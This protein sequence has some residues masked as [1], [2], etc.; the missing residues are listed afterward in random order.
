M[1]KTIIEFKNVSKTYADT[2]T[3]V[4]KDISF[5]LEEG[6]FYT[7]LGA[8]GSGKSTILNIIAG[9][10]DATDGDVILDDKRINDLPAN[11]RNVHTIFQ[12]YALFPNMNVF[13]NVA[14]A[15]KIKGVDKK[16]IAKR[17]SESLKLVRLDGFEKRSITKLSGGQK[18]RVAIARAI[19]DRPKV[20]LLDES[21][22]ALD[23]KLRKDMQY[24]L[25]ELQKSLG[26]TFIFVTHDQE[27]ALA[28]SDWVFI[29]NEGEI[30]Q[31]G[32]PTDIY[33]EPINHFVADFIGESNI[34]N[35]K[36]IE[37]Y[38]VEFNG[39]KFEAVD[40]GMRKNEPIEVVIRP[41]DIWFTLPNEGKFNVKVDTQ[42]FRGVH[43]EIVA[44]DEFNNEWLIHSTHKAIV[45]ETVG[46]DFDPEAIHIMRLN[47]SEEEFDARIE[48]YVE[49]EETVGL[50]KAVEE[51][52]AEEEAAI[53]EAVKEALENTME[54]TELAETVNEI[55]QKQE[56]ETENSESGD[57]K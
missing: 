28:M 40:G 34:L 21:L 20:L 29:M 47:E 51:E 48:E 26:I 49:E 46:L 23:M 12:S 14:F 37:D 53:Q 4:L 1:S 38:L 13:D 55:L 33:D 8:S 30:V 11:K 15:L 7:L 5:E 27:E 24:E 50:A 17:V 10:L 36:M 3:T 41:E 31:S 18:Q 39:Q 56:N 57:H 44:Y 35:G 54:L 6:K 25:R 2:D 9:L 43:Y 19:I 22:S 45:G 52:N 16:E 42:L 32:T